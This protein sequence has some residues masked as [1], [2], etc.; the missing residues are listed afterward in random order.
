MGFTANSRYL[1]LVTDDNKIHFWSTQLDDLIAQ[2]L[3][4]AYEL[5]QCPGIKVQNPE[6]RDFSLERW[7]RA[8]GRRCG[9]VFPWL[10]FPEVGIDQLRKEFHKIVLQRIIIFLES[11]HCEPCFIRKRGLFAHCT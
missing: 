4:E 5:L 7:G 1:V 9:S 6:A 2:V 11:F 10:P 8:E 3:E